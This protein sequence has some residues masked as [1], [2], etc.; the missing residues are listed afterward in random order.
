MA[1]YFFNSY[2]LGFGPRLG[3]AYQLNSKTVLRAGAALLIGGTAD[4]GIEA[5]S[6]TS[7]NI[8]NSTSWAQAPMRLATGVPL[9]YAQIAWPNFSP[10]LYPVVPVAGTPG[11]ADPTGWIDRNAGYPSKSYQWSVGVQREVVRNLV[12]NAAY[13]GNRGV[14]LPSAGAVNYNA[15][16]P[17]ALLA[18]GLDIPQASAR[19]IL[20]AQI[21]SVAAGPFQNRLPYAGFPLTSTVEQAL[22]P[23][24]QFTNAPAALFAPLGDN[25]YDS[26]QVRVIK[27]LSHGLDVSYNFTWSKTLQNGIEGGENDPFNRAQDKYI[28]GSDRPLVSNI[29]ATYTVPVAPWTNNK[30]LKSVLRDWNVGG[31]FTYAS[32]TPIAVPGASANLLSTETFETASFLNEVPGQSPFLTNLNCHCFDPTKTFVLNPAA[33]SLPAPGTWG[34]SAEY[35]NNYRTQRHPTENF[36]FGRTFRIRESMSLSVRAEFVNIFNRTVLPGPSS[37]TPLTAP[38]CFVSGTTGA[39]GA[40][41]NAGATIASGFGY[42]NTVLQA[43]GARTGQLVARFRF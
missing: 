27:R 34:N 7:T 32:G 23:F 36:N 18:D 35:Y 38:T 41:T 19:A 1:V 13:V 15:N 17:Q 20:G 37:S 8:V 30:I 12:V 42:E 5:R 3:A 21:G 14:W 6:V 28:S 9:T 11:T 40:C 29:N 22:R 33:W 2:K 16:T 31:L 24:P 4:N 43:T 26:L 25:W 39:T 10:S